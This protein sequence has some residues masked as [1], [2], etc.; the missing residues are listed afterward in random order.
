MTDADKV[1]AALEVVHGLTV[2]EQHA[3]VALFART[4]QNEWIVANGRIIT[5]KCECELVDDWRLFYGERLTKA[6]LVTFREK[7]ARGLHFV[8]VV[9][10]PLGTAVRDAWW[11][12]FDAEHGS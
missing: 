2:V 1:N 11:A 3:F 12:E 4:C 5:G 7:K 9:P 10:T 8:Y 6:G